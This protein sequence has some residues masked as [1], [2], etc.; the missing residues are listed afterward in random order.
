MLATIDRAT[1]ETAEATQ[2]LERFLAGIDAEPDALQRIEERLFALRACS[3]K[4]GVQV[5]ALPD[6]QRDLTSRLGLLGDQGDLLTKL[7]KETAA[8]RHAYMTFAKELTAKRTQAA[9]LLE[10]SVAK[11]LPPLKFE[12]AQVKVD[13]RRFAG[14]PSLR[15]RHGPREFPSLHQSRYAAGTDTENRLGG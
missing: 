3:R 7:G 8:A 10:K 14:R 15:R 13:N 11:E 9:A 2:Q 5:D 12:R 6:L 1:N 4:H